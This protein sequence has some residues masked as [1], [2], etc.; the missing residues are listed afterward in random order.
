MKEFVGIEKVA[1]RAGVSASTVSRVLNGSKP[2]SEKLQK[3]V[4]K[5]IQELDYRKDDMA[6]SMKRRKTQNIAIIMPQLQMLYFPEVLRGIETSVEK[7]NY[8][9]LYFSTHYD[10]ELECEYVRMLKTSW[11]DGII[12]D[13][14]CPVERMEEYRKLLEANTSGREVPVISLENNFHSDEI[15]CVTID[16]RLYARKA[17]EHLIECG[18]KKIMMITGY[19]DLQICIENVNGYRDALVNSQIAYDERYVIPCDYTPMGAYKAVK[20]LNKEGLSFDGI[21]AAN[22]AMAIGAIKALKELGIEIPREVAV[23]G[24]D[25]SFVSTLIEPSLSSV[26]VSLREIGYKSAEMLLKRLEQKESR[27][28]TIM[29]DC[30][31]M[32]RNST[33]LSKNIEWEL[34]NWWG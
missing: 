24:F 12:L 22:D 10:F 26:E 5:A 6:G 13:S 30:K 19:M 7:H 2:V 16:N 34:N 29:L 23:I 21:F 4:K 32:V 8:K 3:K 14:C 15:G 18:C 28:R 17:V 9:L 33:D 1:K 25:N 20:R 11:V 27:L 31:L